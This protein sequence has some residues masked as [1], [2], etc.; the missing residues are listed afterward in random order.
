MT[1][2]ADVALRLAEFK[3]VHRD[4]FVPDPKNINEPSIT[5]EVAAAMELTTRAF[6]TP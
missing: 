3:K 5:T 6:N 2:F 4:E 1:V